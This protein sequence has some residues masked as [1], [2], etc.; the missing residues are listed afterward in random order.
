MNAS[1]PTQILSAHDVA[2]LRIPYAARRVVRE[3]V[4]TLIEPPTSPQAGD[5]VLARVDEIGH[6]AQLE[7]ACGRRSRLFVGD[8]IMLVF[9]NRYA[10]DQFE[11]RVPDTLRPCHMVAAGG[12]AAHMIKRHSRARMATRITPLGLLADR[13]GQ[14]LNLSRYALPLPCAKTQ[15]PPVIAILGTSM[16]AGKTETATQL[17][18]GLSRAGL[19]VGAAKVT[20]TGAGNDT[21]LMVDA[22]AMRVL[23]FGDAGMATT[24][25]ADLQAV[26]RAFETLV[27][28]LARDGADVIV[29]EV[30]DGLYQRETHHLVN[31][32]VFRGTVDSVLF[33]AGDAMGSAAGI[34]ALQRA[35][36]PVIA[37][38]GLVTASPLGLEEAQ[39]AHGLPML[40]LEALSSASV[41]ARIGV[42]T[43]P[44]NCA[45]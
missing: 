23:D 19:R 18:K 14:A 27:H 8:R 29:L 12:I 4:A 42:A 16:N 2:A 1:H 33:A 39:R 3:D 30:A 7:L 20:G 41:A 26:E 44:L 28:T 11:A 45:A 37:G 15:L 5:V 17:I 36:L 40:D 31:S 21:G 6:H 13:Q 32:D 25:L 9:G 43:A 22:G 24:Y 34:A 35:G 38:S 10:P